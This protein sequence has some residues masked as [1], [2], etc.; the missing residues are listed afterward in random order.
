[1]RSTRAISAIIASAARCT[2]RARSSAITPSAQPSARKVSREESAITGKIPPGG[3]GPGRGGL[4]ETV[5]PRERGGP[6]GRP[7]GPTRAPCLWGAAIGRLCLTFPAW[8]ALSQRAA[9]SRN[10]R[11]HYRV[12][13]G[14]AVASPPRGMLTEALDSGAVSSRSYGLHARSPAPY[15]QE[16]V[17]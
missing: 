14:M 7:P 5:S 4:G 13:G 16:G 11:L 15:Y 2:D 9:P 6:G 3:L 10:D 8:P 12:E 1:G 17:D